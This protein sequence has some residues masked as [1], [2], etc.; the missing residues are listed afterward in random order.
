MNFEFATS[1]CIL[2]GPG[3]LRRIGPLAGEMGRRA[4]IV[5]GRP[6]ESV[7]ILLRLLDLEERAVFAVSGEPTVEMIRQGVDAARGMASDLVIGFGGGSAIDAGKAIAAMAANPGDV[8]EYLEII[9]GGKA[10]SHAPLPCI[11]IPTTAGTGS[12]VTRNAVIASPAHRVK[13]SLRSPLMLPRL[14]LID[15]ELTLSLPPDLTAS[16]GLDAL[17][18]LIEPY[19]CNAPHPLIDPLCE[20]GIDRV[21]RA[22]ITAYKERDDLQA[23]EDMALA[24]FLG[25]LALAHARLGAVHGIA[26]PLGGMFPAPHGAVCAALLPHV[27]AANIRAM[28]ERDPENPALQRYVKIAQIV[29][30]HPQAAAAD[31][32]AWVADLCQRLRIPPL[33]IYGI[34]PADLPELIDKS[35]RASSMKGNPL[36]LTPAE[37]RDILEKAI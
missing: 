25:G 17:T 23:R 32:A 35:T 8:L 6:A 34:R 28:Q 3:I 15:P 11:A 24:S 26:G 9:G 20:E 4:L 37:L 33:T 19:T 2:F 14:V 31:G 22:L 18:Q 36:P 29:T 5:T 10:I 13:V 12:E 16:T 21:V 27:M 30:G 7:D 1:G